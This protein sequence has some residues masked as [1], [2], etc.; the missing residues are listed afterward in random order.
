MKMK[1]VTIPIS[2][3]SARH[4]KVKYRVVRTLEI[5]ELKAELFDDLD[6]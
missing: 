4:I 1:S 5:E 3:Q 2:L 6:L